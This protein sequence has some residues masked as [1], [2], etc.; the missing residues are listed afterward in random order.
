MAY[1]S[2]LCFFRKALILTAV[3]LSLPLIFPRAATGSHPVWEPV[4]GWEVFGS[5][6]GQGWV[7]FLFGAL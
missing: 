1:L 7:K 2:A 3:F 4:W 5:W 6:S